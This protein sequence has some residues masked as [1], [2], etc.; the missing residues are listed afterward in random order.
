MFGNKEAIIEKQELYMIANFLLNPLIGEALHK[1][2][3]DI[4]FYPNLFAYLW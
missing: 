4:V 1:E 3:V 2:D